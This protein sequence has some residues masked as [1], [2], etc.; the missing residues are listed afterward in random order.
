MGF[1]DDTLRE[2]ESVFRNENALDYEFV[3]KMLPFREDK[4][5]AIAACVKPLLQDRNGRNALVFGAPGI[6]KTAATKWVLKDLEETTDE[7]IPIYVNCWQKNTTHKIFVELCHQ[8]GFMFTQNKNS[9]EL[10]KIIKQHT[11]RKPAV[12]VFDEIDKAEDL[13][14]LYALLNDIYKKSVILIT[15]YKSWFDN[16]EDRIKSRLTPELIEFEEYNPEQIQKILQERISIAFVPGSWHADAFNTIAEKAAMAKDVRTGLYLLH[17]AGLIAEEQASTKITKEHAEKAVAKLG[18]F[19]SK[20]QDEL[21][22]DEKK[23]LLVV[24]ENS[25]KRIGDLFKLYQCGGGKSSYKTFQ[26]RIDK[27]SRANYISSEKITGGKEGT[28]TIVSA[29]KK[30]DEY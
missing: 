18:A 12:F 8:L 3:P 25:G 14:F 1:F 6:G 5:H 27:L 17:E 28:T 11:L 16:I 19:S 9:E 10:F 30:L 20:K 4:Q 2:G 24:K 7:A 29:N 21:D 22:D 23:I 13:D 15:N 26:R